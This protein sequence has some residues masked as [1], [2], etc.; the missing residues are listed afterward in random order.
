[1]DILDFCNSACCLCHEPDGLAIL[2]GMGTKM[3]QAMLSEYRVKDLTTEKGFLCSKILAD[4]GAEVIR[5]DSPG[6]QASSVYANTG[7]HSISLNLDIPKG[8]ELFKHLIKKSDVIV[9]SF[10]PDYLASIGLGYSALARI[11]PGLIMA[12]IT[13]FGSTGPLKDYKG[14]DLVSSALGGQMSVCGQSSNPPL[15]PFGPQAASTACLFAANAVLLALLK[16]HKS[17]KGQ[18]IDISIHECTAATLDHILVRY[19]YQGEVAGRRGSLYWNN[20]FRIFPCRDGYILLTLFYQWETLVEWLNSEGRAGDLTESK[21]LNET[22]RLNHIQH[23]ITIL[24]AWTLEHKIDELVETGQLMHFPWARVA[25]IPDVVNNPQLNKR[26]FF[27]EA[28]DSQSGQ[29]YKFPG[30]PVKMSESP[31]QVNPAIPEAGE[32]NTEVYH[33][34][35]GLKEKE[36]AELKREGVI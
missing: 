35:L 19:F 28:T 14:S 36:I 34:R 22:E 21:W 25:S 11:N 23:I 33:N 32:F 8:K 17:R 18:Y 29:V 26:G 27:A 13:D 6:A 7:K 24:E 20:S 2:D 16:R 10:P 30:A 1:V 5:I 12:S 9:E 4:M 31:W 3:N 15:K